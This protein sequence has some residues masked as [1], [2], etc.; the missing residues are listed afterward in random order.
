[1]ILMSDHLGEPIASQVVIPSNFNLDWWIGCSLP[2]F[3]RSS[4][5]SAGK[6]LRST[7]HLRIENHPMP[8]GSGLQRMQYLSTPGSVVDLWGTVVAGAALDLIL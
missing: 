5:V 8:W 2:S 7:R 6:H 1:M 4:L 3:V